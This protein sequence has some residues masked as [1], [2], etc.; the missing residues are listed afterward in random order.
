MIWPI[1]SLDRDGNAM[2]CIAEVA[3]EG[4]KYEIHW[5]IPNRNKNFA[6]RIMKSCACIVKEAFEILFVYSR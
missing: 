3:V 5:H 2:W 1:S 6:M 4:N